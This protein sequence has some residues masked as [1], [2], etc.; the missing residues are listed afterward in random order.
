VTAT[1]Q[2]V[3]KVVKGAKRT[4][5][6]IV[7]FGRA[8]VVTRRAATV[9]L[10]IRGRAAALRV[11]RADAGAYRIRIT[12]TSRS[13]SAKPVTRKLLLGSSVLR[14]LEASAERSLTGP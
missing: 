6:K 1:A 7:L 12:L 13:G 10:V 4:L 2:L 5:R 8:T 9:R 11:Y 3:P 14:G